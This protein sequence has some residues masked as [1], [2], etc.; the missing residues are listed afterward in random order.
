MKNGSPPR[1][2]VKIDLDDKYLSHDIVKQVENW[3]KNQ[4]FSEQY[5]PSTV[6]YKKKLFWSYK[7]KI[8]KLET[9]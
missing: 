9:Y 5:A 2:Q 6:N 4:R 3:M 8:S 1:N 7:A